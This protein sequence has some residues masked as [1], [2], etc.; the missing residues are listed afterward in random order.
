MDENMPM[1]VAAALQML[2]EEM[3]EE[4]ERAS[5]VDDFVEWLSKC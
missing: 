3:L 4:E 1:G 5:A 2:N